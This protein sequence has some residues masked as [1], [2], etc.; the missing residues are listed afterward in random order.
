[1]LTNWTVHQQSRQKVGDKDFSK[2]NKMA[3][4]H[5]ATTPRKQYD[6]RKSVNARLKDP[7]SRGA[8]QHLVLSENAVFGQ[9]NRPS[10]PIKA[11]VEGFFG[12]VAEQQS[13]QRYEIIARSTSKRPTTSD[14]RGHTR[15]SAL[16]RDHISNA[17]ITDLMRRTTGEGLFKMRK[18]QNVDPRT[19]THNGK[20]SLFNLAHKRSTSQAVTPA[21]KA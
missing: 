16:A 4:S 6:F 17:S 20:N 15:A 21:K 19:N 2:L 10:T 5:K 9:P 11:V 1:M 18:F 14:L 8:I 13:L 7:L 3:L 12:D